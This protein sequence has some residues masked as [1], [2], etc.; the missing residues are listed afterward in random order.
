MTGRRFLL[1]VELAPED[2]SPNG[3]IR[4]SSWSDCTILN[5]WFLTV[6]YLDLN[7]GNFH[8]PIKILKIYLNEYYW[9]FKFN[10]PKSKLIGEALTVRV[11]LR[12]RYTHFRYNS[13]TGSESIS[14]LRLN[15][16]PQVLVWRYTASGTGIYI[17]ECTCAMFILMNVLIIEILTPKFLKIFPEFSTF[18]ARQENKSFLRKRP[19]N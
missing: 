10:I 2:S 1:K 14:S 18:Y 9:W 3:D 8:S 5:Y 11:I 15:K 17:P 4:K 13:L 7:G 19:F 6:E 12:L 16:D